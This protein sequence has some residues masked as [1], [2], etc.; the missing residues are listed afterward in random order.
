MYTGIA[1]PKSAAPAFA[2][3]LLA[4]AGAA[5][6][7]SLATGGCP[8]F[9]CTLEA[10]ETVS[11][12][13][14]PAITTTVINSALGVMKAQGCSGDGTNLMCIFSTDHAT[15]LAQGTLKLIDGTTLQ[16]IWGSAGV[17]GSYNLVARSAATGQVPTV[18]ADGTFAA[19]DAFFEVLYDQSGNVLEQV[20]LGGPANTTNFGLTPISDRYGIVS[21]TNGVLTLIDLTTWTVLGALALEDQTTN[22]PL[23]LVSPSTGAPNVLYAAAYNSTTGTGYLISVG[24]NATGTGL[25][26]LSTYAY[27]GVTG[28]SAVIATPSVTGLAG[29][30]VL[31]NAPG[32]LGQSPP[33]NQ[34]LG[35]L[36]PGVGSMAEVWSIP[37]TGALTV[38]PTFDPVSLTMYYVQKSGPNLYQADLLTGAALQTFDIQAMAA[39][40]STFGINGHLA[41]GEGDGPFTVLLSGGT[42]GKGRA[43][44]QYAIAIQPLVS[45]PTLQWVSAI[46]LEA[47]SYTAAWNFV[48]SSQ[49]G[50]AC[51]VAIADT[52]AT[53]TD[54]VRLCDF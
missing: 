52:G 48:P 30:L 28:A 47:S 12:S 36:D 29:N 14:V 51:P 42:T 7:Q 31:L 23:H 18:F 54:I 33:E 53:R 50:V 37:L 3:V 45:P 20:P 43:A 32:T 24:V 39:L 21:Q 17:P 6:A 41:A 11:A 4:S 19:G 5:Y 16:P 10:T 27:T 1:R 15:G 46:K 35:I 9:H 26:V 38:A 13:L 34:L 44:E 8:M 25:T 49:P 22:Q 40:P 2:A